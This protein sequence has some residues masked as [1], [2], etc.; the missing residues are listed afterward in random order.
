MI[1]LLISVIAIAL[2]AAALFCLMHYTPNWAKTAPD[3][4]RVLAGS[5]SSFE[6]AFYR[7]GAANHGLL[8]EPT[9]T[10]DG[11]LSQFQTP[12]RYLAF[13]PKAPVGFMWT[14][15]RSA[16]HYVCLQA[17]DPAQPLDASVFFGVKRLSRMLPAGQLVVSEG[18]RSCG[19]TLDVTAGPVELPQRLSITF[20]MRYSAS[21]IP[22]TAAFPCYGN[23][24]LSPATI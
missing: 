24:C 11:G 13:M 20:F 9:A 17:I 8:P 16:S 3:H 21:G 23:A 22:S 6:T 14:Y 10:P 4:T 7:F 2:Q 5:L 1:N 12:G 18:S 19:S 15:G